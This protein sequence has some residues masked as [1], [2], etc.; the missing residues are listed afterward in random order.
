MALLWG[1]VKQKLWVLS[2]Y[3]PFA[4]FSTSLG[5]GKAKAMN[6]AALLWSENNLLKMW[7][8]SNGE[9]MELA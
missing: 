9:Y 8:F 6:G 2:I 4:T 3:D 7:S 5:A 1:L